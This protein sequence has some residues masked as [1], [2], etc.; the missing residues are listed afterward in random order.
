MAQRHL[1]VEVKIEQRAKQGRQACGDVASILRSET[2][3]S[4]IVCDGV[5]SGAAAHVA[6][7]MC[8]AR[9]E[10]ML[11]RGFSLRETF[12]RI[13][14]SMEQ[15]KQ[16][17]KPYAAFTI[18]QIRTNGHTQAMAYESPPP[19]WVTSRQAQ[20]LGM[21]RFM[22][23]TIAGSEATCYLRNGEGLMLLS[24]GITQAGM[25]THPGGWQAHGVAETINRLLGKHPM[26]ELPLLI[27]QKAL[28]L[29]KGIDHDDATVAWIACRPA[30]PL[31]ILTGPPADKARDRPVV[32]RFMAM[33]GP[34]VVCG[35]TTAEIVARVLG[36]TLEIEKEPAS[37][38]AP[39]KYLLEGVDLVTEGAVTL[40]QLNNILEL[41]PD[42]LYEI[43]AVT[44]L[45][46]LMTDADRLYIT[47][48]AGK[49]PAN[50]DTC[51][52]QR[53][54]LT[55]EKII[56]LIADKLRRQGKCVILETA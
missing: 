49:N 35:A 2:E 36:R 15:Y 10:Q 37:L 7:A 44:D 1:H 23:D 40:N 6:A 45:Y 56:P 54:V 25:D 16:P 14:A 32:E 50:E 48:G 30:R 20:P 9:C 55:R 53:G 5:G 51:F 52:V 3:T 28:S 47:L 12:L 18:A 29:N 46:D 34:K 41:D 11:N 27:Q 19:I 31:N 42:A 39:P 26:A 4:V 21:R 22:H 17:G 24:D 8:R 13:A 38:I 33:P 43:N